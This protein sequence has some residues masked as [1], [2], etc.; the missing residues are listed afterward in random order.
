M[1]NFMLAHDSGFTWSEEEQGS[2]RTDFFP[3]VNF[4]VIS[5]TP[6]VEHNFPI[7]QVYMKTYVLLF[8]KSLL[9][10]S[11]SHRTHLIGPGGFAS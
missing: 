4:P 10:A 9:L 8:R 1:H 3:P 11:M 2:F 7:P 6:W 5:H